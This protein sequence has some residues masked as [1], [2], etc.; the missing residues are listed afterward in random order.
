M[1][2][3]SQP[4]DKFFKEVFS[5]P[6]VGKDFLLNY[7]PSE[8]TELLNLESLEL[9]RD[10]FL[11]KRLR[12]HFSD[13]IYKAQLKDGTEVYVY[14]LLEHKSYPAY[15]VA[16]QLLRSM[17]RIWERVL[18]KKE[19]DKKGKKGKKDLPFY[20]PPIIPI[21][22]YHGKPKWNVALN[23]RALFSPHLKLESYIPNFSYVPYDI[24]HY[25]DD[26]IKGRVIL[27]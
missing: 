27:K 5:R 25:D 22:I 23:F 16:F 13:I 26:E 2:E 8:I 9:T 15:L 6:G 12:A 3:I 7:L 21:V 17:V 10:S 19:E 1:K 24:S 11:D 20:L 18:R 4:H 14:A